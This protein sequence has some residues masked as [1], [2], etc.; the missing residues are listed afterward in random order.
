MAGIA[1]SGERSRRPSQD[2]TPDTI[3]GETATII[4]Q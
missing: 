4:A 2:R 1:Q 3:A